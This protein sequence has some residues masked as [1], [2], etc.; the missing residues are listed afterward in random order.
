MTQDSYNNYVANVSNRIQ[1][2]GDLL[3]TGFQNDDCDLEKK[4]MELHILSAYIDILSCW[5][6]PEEDSEGVIENENCLS[7]AEMRL[8]TYHINK[9]T[10][11][12]YCVDYYKRYGE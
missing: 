2:I 10:G 1:Q 5:T 9:I 4:R 7:I 6:L 12:N 8:I 3:V 11:D